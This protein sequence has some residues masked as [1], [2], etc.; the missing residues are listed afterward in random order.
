MN[1]KIVENEC[2]DK[3]ITILDTRLPYFYAKVSELFSL[4]P[5]EVEV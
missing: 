2:R 1:I 5:E 3:E 4:E